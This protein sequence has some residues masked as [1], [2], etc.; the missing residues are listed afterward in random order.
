MVRFSS[1]RDFLFTFLMLILPCVGLATVF[2]AVA[3]AHAPAATLAEGLTA[4]MIGGGLLIAL[5]WLL[6]WCWAETYY[7]VDETELRYRSGVFRGGIDLRRI[8]SVKKADYPNTGKRPAL[9]L[10]G[11]MIDYEAGYLLF[12]SPADE[13]GFIEALKDRGVLP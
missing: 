13:A 2:I 4:L 12:V 11:L 5:C 6:I 1:R 7:E 10:T 9:A 3:R 8:N